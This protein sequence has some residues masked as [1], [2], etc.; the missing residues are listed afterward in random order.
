MP[1][2]TTLKDLANLAGVSVSTVSKA[3]N[4]SPEIGLK[5]RVRIKEIAE[6][7]NYIPNNIARSL[8]S[9]STKTIGVVIPAILLEFFSKV[10]YGIEI[11]AT[12]RGYK[13]IICLSN[14]KQKKESESIDTF[15]NGSVDGIILSLAEETQ[16]LKSY[17]HLDKVSKYNVPMV[18]FDRVTK[19][20][21]C[22]TVTIDDFECSYEATAF[23]A[24]HGSKHIAFVNPISNISVGQLRCEGYLKALKDRNLKPLIIDVD[25]YNQIEKDL[26]RTLKEQK[27]DGVVCADEYSAILTINV[28]R[29]NGFDVPNDIAVIGFTNGLMS[30]HSIPSLTV[31]SQ[32]AE[33]IG[34]KAVELLIDRLEG[35]LV[36]DP[37]HE[38]IHTHIIERN[39][40]KKLN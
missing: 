38:V 5:T 14:E 21:F 12:K 4:D 27:I 19:D 33:N 35:K 29:L 39:S 16:R 23:L 30:E 37:V 32:H 1:S 22:D 17:A 2:K 13:L 20:V 7:C 25:H 6:S 9:K 34:K 26:T 36:S 31:V 18:M 40:T 8:K 28:A 15:I 11:E 24:D 10:L 3:L